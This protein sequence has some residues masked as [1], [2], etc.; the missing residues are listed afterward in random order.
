[1]KT[2][3]KWAETVRIEAALSRLRLIQIIKEIQS[4]AIES[5][6]LE[7]PGGSSCDPQIAADKIRLLIP[8]ETNDNH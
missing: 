6:L 2:A 4:D 3:E 1:M 8:K 5:A 7:L